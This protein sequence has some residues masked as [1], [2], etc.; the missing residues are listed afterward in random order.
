MRHWKFLLPCLVAVTL[1]ADDNEASS[2]PAPV[3]QGADL[4]STS[5]DHDM[6]LR[7]TQYH[8]VDLRATGITFWEEITWGFP[9]GRR[10]ARANLPMGPRGKLAF[11]NALI[12]ALYQRGIRQI[13]VDDPKALDAETIAA[14]ELNGINVVVVDPEDLDWRGLHGDLFTAFRAHPDATLILESG[15]FPGW[16]AGVVQTQ[17]MRATDT[18]PPLEFIYFWRNGVNSTIVASNLLEFALFTVSDEYTVPGDVPHPPL[19]RTQSEE[20]GEI[21]CES[22]QPSR[23]RPPT[24]EAPT[25]PPSPG[26]GC[27][28]L[29]CLAVVSW[30]RHRGNPPHDKRSEPVTLP[31]TAEQN[32]TCEREMN[33]AT[34]PRRTCDRLELVK[35]GIKLAPGFLEGTWDCLGLS[36]PGLVG[37][38]PQKIAWKPDS[39]T[40]NWATLDLVRWLGPG[41]ASIAIDKISRVNLTVENC[42]D[43]FGIHNDAFKV[44][45]GYIKAKCVGSGRNATLVYPSIAGEYHHSRHGPIR[46]MGP[47]ETFASLEVRPD[48]WVITP[49]CQTVRTLEVELRLGSNLLHTDGGTWDT[50]ALSLGTFKTVSLVSRPSA[51]SVITDDVD[52]VT[53]FGSLEADIG[54]ITSINLMSIP[55]NGDKWRFHG[56]TFNARCADGSGKIQLTKYSNVDKWV[57]YNEK[58]QFVWS[59]N[60]T[61]G[62]WENME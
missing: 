2:T 48:A 26:S 8:R 36:L 30:I 23:P 19:S 28:P 60:V 9:F 24:T 11:S 4:P 53:L 49:R 32:K 42:G 33:L 10:L 6:D 34:R 52:L 57:E 58:E 29:G 54:D 18:L 27:L 47:A 35:I 46:E 44:Q 61:A 45:E 21:W 16:V 51:A 40:D 31:P 41:T 1:A 15:R 37:P 43:F 25:A 38:Y 55:G 5:Q 50:I 56:I 17:S 20:D 39:G 59:G 13:I 3:M 14:F 22:L 12:V 62:D 7:G